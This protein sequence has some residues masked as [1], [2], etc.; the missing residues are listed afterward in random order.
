MSFCLACGHERTGADRFCTACR[1]EFRDL[2]QPE[3]PVTDQDRPDGTVTGLDLFWETT[4]ADPEPPVA[5]PP[6]AGSAYPGP[7]QAEPPAGEPFYGQPD[8]ADVGSYPG[9]ARRRPGLRD[10]I[11]AV[12]LAAVILLAAAGGAYALVT[13]RGHGQAAGKP[14]ETAS[15]AASHATP[16]SEAPT[17]PAPTSPAPTTS[18]PASQ[19][20]SSGTTVAV[21]SGAA[22]NPAAPQVTAMVNHYFTAINQHDYSAFASLLDQQMKQRVPESAFDSGYATTID[23]AE[24]LTSI[25]DTGSGGLAASLTFTSQQSPADSPDNSSCDRWSITLFLDPNGTGY[26]IGAPPSDYQASYRA[27]S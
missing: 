22:S 4:A 16:T 19:T 12:A 1:T 27:C 18:A 2:T 15:I 17:S 9:P 14:A 11:I 3:P 21:A 6:Y 10:N 24:T 8:D 7:A 25:S 23:S 13:S 5:E 26:L 20:A